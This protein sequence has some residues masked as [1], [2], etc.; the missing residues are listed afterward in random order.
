MSEITTLW[1]VG[2]FFVVFSTFSLGYLRRD[3]QRRG[4]LSR[5]GS[6][7]HVMMYVVNG[8]FVGMLIWGTLLVPPMR[9][10]P[11]LGVPLMVVGFGTLVVAMDLFRGFSRWLGSAT[12]G[13]RTGGVYGVSRNPQ[14]VAY[15]LLIIGVVVAW[16][17]P[18]GWLGLLSYI[19]LVHFV[20][21]LEEEHLSRVYGQSYRDYCERV[22]RFVGWKGQRT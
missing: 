2:A 1:A 15:G 4:K 12:P 3:Y 18:R 8:M 21:R 7:V 16:G 22:P 13:L 20:V 10:R 19:V 5:V 17:E 14:L 6:L 9:G 11:W